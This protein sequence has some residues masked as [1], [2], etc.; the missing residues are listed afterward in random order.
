MKKTLICAMILALLFCA[1]L[2][3]EPSAPETTEPSAPETTEAE[4]VEIAFD[5]A[6][7][8]YAGA[9]VPFEDGF[10]LYLPV[11]WRAFELSDA[12]R[13]AGLFYRAG[14]D[15]GDTPMGVAVG[16]F[17]AGAL[18]T[19]D[20]LE[21]DFAAAGF[22]GLERREANGLPA[23]GFVRPAEN[24]RGAAFFHPMYPGYVLMVYVTPLG[25]DGSPGMAV[26]QAILDSLG[27][28]PME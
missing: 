20:D 14:G 23:L 1:A 7:A 13:E 8:G 28:M 15:G 12:E 24:Y 27:P 11:H 16:Y 22:T 18:R 4:P 25:E 2:A 17:P 3:E 6:L 26:G 5:E 21:A 10:R 19:L 9:W